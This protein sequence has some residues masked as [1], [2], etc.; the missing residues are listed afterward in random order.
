MM[1]I[2]SAWRPWLSCLACRMLSLCRG[3][4]LNH[5][6]FIQRFMQ[7]DIFRF[8]SMVL[9]LCAFILMCTQSALED[10]KFVV[11]ISLAV[12]GLLIFCCIL[13]NWQTNEKDTSE[14]NRSPAY[15]GPSI[16]EGDSASDAPSHMQDR[17]TGDILNGGDGISVL[18][19]TMPPALVQVAHSRFI[20][21]FSALLQAFQLL[22]LPEERRRR[23][24]AHNAPV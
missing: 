17:R 3:T 10:A 11:G 6:V 5:C 9:F 12:S 16:N 20:E 4:F 21:F 22:Y 8:Y 7:T 13:L 23:G 18:A 1:P 15:T 2:N 14:Q 19:N 24:E